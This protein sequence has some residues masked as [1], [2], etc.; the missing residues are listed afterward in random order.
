MTEDTLSG[1]KGGGGI[2]HCARGNPFREM[3]GNL[4]LFPVKVVGN[5]PPNSASGCGVIIFEFDIA[6]DLV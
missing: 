5:F 1:K 4:P 6:E 2:W 3:A